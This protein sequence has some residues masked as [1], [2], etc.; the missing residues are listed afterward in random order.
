MARSNKEINSEINQM[1]TP[2]AGARRP[3]GKPDDYDDS[4]NKR[5]IRPAEAVRQATEDKGATL[6]CVNKQIGVDEGNDATH[7]KANTGQCNCL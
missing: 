1:G 2:E 5:H 6:R 4:L 7:T 3:D